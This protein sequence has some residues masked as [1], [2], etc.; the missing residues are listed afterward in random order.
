MAVGAM[1]GEPNGFEFGNLGAGSAR[2]AQ[3]RLFL[4]YQGF[5][6]AY[7]FLVSFK[8]TFSPV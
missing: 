7:F 8:T 6:S 4:V 5:S 1:N 2:S 3:S